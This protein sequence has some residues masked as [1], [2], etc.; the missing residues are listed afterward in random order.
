[1]SETTLGTRG[2]QVR[3]GVCRMSSDINDTRLEENPTC[4][5]PSKHSAD[6]VREIPF[7]PAS[8]NGILLNFVPLIS[9]GIHLMY[10]SSSNIIHS[11]VIEIKI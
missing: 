6:P 4:C 5:T 11:L 1:M 3:N 7:L 10:I 8:T 2:C 9:F